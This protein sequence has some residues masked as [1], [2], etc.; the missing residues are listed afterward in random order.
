M[1][2][3]EPAHYGGEL[4]MGLIA[5]AGPD[6][7]ARARRLRQRPVADGA[8]SGLP[9]HLH[10]VLRRVYAARGVGRD[11]LAPAL[12]GLIAV[13][14]LPGACAAA[15]CLAALRRESGRVLVVGDF[16]ADGATATALMLRCLRGFG[17]GEAAYLVPN[18]FTYGY[19]LSPAIVELAARQAPAAIVTVDNGISSIE[20]VRRAADLGIPVIVTDHHV[21]GD[22]LP[23]AEVIASPLLPGTDFPS[24]SLCGVGV[25]F[26]VMAALARHLADEGALAADD[27]RA[28][29]ASALDLVALGTV[30][31][32][33]RLDFNNR[34]LVAEGLRRIRAGQSRPGI[35]ALF[36]VAGRDWRRAVASD[37]GFAVA[38]RLNAAGRM[39]DMSLGIEC[40]LADTDELA[41]DL[42]GRLDRLNAERREVQARMQVEADRLLASASGAGEGGDAAGICLY[43]PDWHEG[44]VGL[45][46][47]RTREA[48]GRPVVA[49]APAQEAGRL[50][51]SARSVPGLH[52]RDAIAVAAQ[53]LPEGAV[54]FGGHAMAAG[55]SL[56]KHHLEAFAAAF[57]HAVRSRA[58]DLDDAETLWTDGPLH[59]GL[60]GLELA[61]LLHEAGPWGQGFPEPVFED[62]FLVLERRVVGADHLR[63]R[64]RE[65]SSGAEIV[66]I[67]F[68]QA[69]HAEH[70][71]GSQIRVAYRLGLNHYRGRASAQAVVE[72]IEY[73]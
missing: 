44:V 32:L 9:D 29:V 34:I 33:V 37:L 61:E 69:A 51:G 18:R 45:V 11:E 31:D 2:L 35:R 52:L 17:F 63:M 71:L 53:A 25:A 72:H 15:E 43:D 13:S 28:L 5:A 49:F 36:Q 55:V 21:P 14:R 7:A 41:V 58:A 8:I 65:A 66:G 64:L 48:S 67:A 19:G 27:A 3:R 57:D 23:D 4:D 12:G 38:P 20:G 70:V 73:E 1:W 47:T 39:D 50:R 22:E 59:D 26:Y 56:A 10:P 24:P 40:L 6:A 60:R 54:R 46:A 42:A 62:R 30:A 68:R 16:D